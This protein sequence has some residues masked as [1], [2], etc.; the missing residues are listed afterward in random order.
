MILFVPVIGLSIFKPII[1][2]AN[3]ILQDI[4]AKE[5]FKIAL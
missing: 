2:S 3:L 1:L 5:N 4:S